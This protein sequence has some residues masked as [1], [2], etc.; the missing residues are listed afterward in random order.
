[1]KILL[2]IVFCGTAVC[3]HAY[4]AW[5]EES[6]R[7]EADQVALWEKNLAES[8]RKPLSERLPSLWLGLRNMGYRKSYDGHSLGVDVIY[9]KIQK[10]ILSTPGHARYFVDD[11]EKLR[12]EGK[13]TSTERHQYIVETLRHLPSPE[14]I[15]VLGQLL[16]DEQDA[17]PPAVEGQDW[18]SLPAN[19]F[20]AVDALGGIGLRDAPVTKSFLYQDRAVLDA[21]RAWW[22][23]VKSG[24]RTFSFKG[25]AVE[26][27]FKPDGTWDTLAMSNPP[28]DGR[29]WPHAGESRLERRPATAAAHMNQSDKTAKSRPWLLAASALL[30]GAALWWL[31][32]KAHGAYRRSQ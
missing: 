8:Q 11:L 28:D 4:A 6:R 3:S 7:V 24:K 18:T 20:L 21:N 16:S 26:Y 5:T 12:A 14:T 31:M 32:R 30:L 25:Q 13:W 19:C 22:E 23:E 10:E 29:G 2:L 17:P 1:M 9:A 15:Q 27:R